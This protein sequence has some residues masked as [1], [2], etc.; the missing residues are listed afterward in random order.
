[1]VV[2]AVKGMEPSLEECVA[3]DEVEAF[4]GRSAQIA[5]DEVG[6][7]RLS[8]NCGVELQIAEHHTGKYMY[9]QRTAL[10]QV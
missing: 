2:I 1:M 5:D 6:G 4:T 8:A 9:K 10:G 7:V 3:E